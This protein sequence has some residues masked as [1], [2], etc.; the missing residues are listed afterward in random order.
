MGTFVLL[1]ETTTRP[2]NYAAN[3]C[4]AAGIYYA[5]AEQPR[6]RATGDIHSHATAD[7]H[8]ACYTCAATG[9]SIST[10]YAIRDNDLTHRRA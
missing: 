7:T 8:I 9:Y 5:T 10:G 3:A 2:G 4:G 6:T 1:A